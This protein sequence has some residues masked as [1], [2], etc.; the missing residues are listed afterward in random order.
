MWCGSLIPMASYTQDGSGHWINESGQPTG[1]KGVVLKQD[2]NDPT[3]KNS[4]FEIENQDGSV[5]LWRGDGSHERKSAAEVGGSGYTF[6]PPP[7]GR[8]AENARINDLL[9]RYPLNDNGKLI[10]SELHNL[11][12]DD[13]DL[14]HGRQVVLGPP[15]YG[16]HG[17]LYDEWKNLPGVEKRSSSHDIADP[18]VQQYQLRLGPG[19]TVVLFGK[20]KD[21]NTFLAFERHA[22][23]PSDLSL[24]DILGDFDALSRELGNWEWNVG[25]NHNPFT[26]KDRHGRDKD[27]S[28]WLGQGVGPFGFNDK[29]DLYVR[30]EN[31]VPPPGPSPIPPGDQDPLQ[32]IT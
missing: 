22:G 10:V 20:T 18:N 29:P 30:Y 13:V 7:D 9:N 23:R 24:P 19:D 31:F 5:D 2:S 4:K 1:W 17:Q 11:G 32:P 26:G 25:V 3:G 16:D 28:V 21:G 14:F 8:A 15:P 12:I 27:L 6:Y